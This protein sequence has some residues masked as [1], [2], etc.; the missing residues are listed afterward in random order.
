MQTFFVKLERERYVQ[1]YAYHNSL[2]D[3]DEKLREGEETEGER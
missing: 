2:P 3:K 1:G